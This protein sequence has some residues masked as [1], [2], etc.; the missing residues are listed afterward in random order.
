MNR[1]T[2][3][4]AIEYASNRNCT[5]L[6]P[7]TIATLEAAVAFL[8]VERRS[9][10]V[11]AYCNANLSKAMRPQEA[12]SKKSEILRRLLKYSVERVVVEA[13]NSIEEAKNIHNAL[14]EK[15]MEP[16][17]IVIFCDIQHERRLRVIWP[18]VFPGTEIEIR[19]GRYIYGGDYK[20]IFLR[21][22]FTWCLANVGGLVAM[23]LFGID[24]VA[25]IKEP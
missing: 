4:V 19:H 2:V 17:K 25:S 10:F 6:A 16:R 21:N 3:A 15:S 12:E 24:R 14:A 1:I 22:Q 9:D 7:A 18:H 8:N 11:L 20:Q 23:K 5:G 13:G